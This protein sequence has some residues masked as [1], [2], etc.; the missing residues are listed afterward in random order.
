MHK[1]SRRMNQTVFYLA[2]QSYSLTPNW[3]TFIISSVLI[4]ARPCMRAFSRP[5]RTQRYFL[6]V[7]V[8]PKAL[9]TVQL[10]YHTN[11]YPRSEVLFMLVTSSVTKQLSGIAFL[12]FECKTFKILGSNTNLCSRVA[13]QA[14]TSLQN[15]R[16]WLRGGC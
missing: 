16:C 11:V 6:S 1:A 3:T 4:I 7:A 2:S 12:A 9:Y 13:Y 15:Y 5:P 14:F 8:V 10:R